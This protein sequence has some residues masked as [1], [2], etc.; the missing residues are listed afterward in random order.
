MRIFSFKNFV[1]FIVQDLVEIF[2]IVSNKIYEYEL[3]VSSTI[4]DVLLLN[5]AILGLMHNKLGSSLWQK[6]DAKDLFSHN[7]RE[8]IQYRKENESKMTDQSSFITF[9]KVY[10]HQETFVL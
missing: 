4:M 3:S 6:F 1:L 5:N 8:G 10:F 7:F 2:R 9:I